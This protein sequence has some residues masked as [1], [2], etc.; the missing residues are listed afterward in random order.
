MLE[1]A[2]RDA[3][4]GELDDDELKLLQQY[5]DDLTVLIEELKSAD[6]P[7]AQL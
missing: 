4:L 3:G 2:A 5:L 6:A 7:G 1:S